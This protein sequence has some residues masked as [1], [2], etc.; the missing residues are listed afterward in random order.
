MWAQRGLSSLAVLP[1]WLAGNPI[2][3]GGDM[4]E[5]EWERG[6]WRRGDGEC[7]GSR[8]EGKLGE[9]MGW[10]GDGE[11]GVGE[12]GQGWGGVWER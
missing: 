12:M 6:V 1:L 3:W 8:W 11:D 5:M 7:G 10:D 4:G 9:V 2:V